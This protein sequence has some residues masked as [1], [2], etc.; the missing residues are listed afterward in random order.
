MYKHVCLRSIPHQLRLSL[1]GLTLYLGSLISTSV[2]TLLE[3]GRSRLS[4]S[5]PHVLAQ[6]AEDWSEIFKLRLS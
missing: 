2:T 3:E 1:L 4:D 6:R 5:G